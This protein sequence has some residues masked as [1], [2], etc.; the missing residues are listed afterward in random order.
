MNRFDN[1]TIVVTGAGSGIG[2][3]TVERL[4]HE[5]AFVVAVDNRAEALEGL[6]SRIESKDRVRTAVADIA[7]AQHAQHFFDKIVR[8]L[9]VVDGLV[10]SAG[11]RG[12]GTVLDTPAE[13]LRRVLAVNL[14]GTC[15]MCRSFA[16]AAQS[17]GN[18]GAIVNIS[19][20]A[21]LRG[22]PNRLSYAASK[23]GVTGI[24]ATM[25]IELAPLGIRVNA[26]APGMTR[27]PMTSPMFQDEAN[28]SKIRA[29][30]PLGREGRPDEIAGPIAFLLSEDASFITGATLAVDGGYTAGVPSF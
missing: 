8:E 6:L 24:T 14:E 28:V 25:G 5:G 4:L 26:V 29:S 17:A 13:K 9:G 11:I 18:G 3:A 19:S 23:W 2:A 7:D 16:A 22:N 12:V 20:S 10:N 15:N 1:K 21:G 27:T 30:H